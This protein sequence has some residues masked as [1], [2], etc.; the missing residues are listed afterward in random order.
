MRDRRRWLPGTLALTLTVLG[1]T[2]GQAQNLPLAPQRPEGLAA[3]PIFEGWYPN[4]DGTITLSFGYLNR[5]TE[6]ILDIPVGPSNFVSPGAEDQGQPTHFN[7]R[8]HYGLFTVTVPGDFPEDQRVRWTIDIRGQRFSIPGG[9]IQGYRIDALYAPA[10]DERPPIVVLEEGGPEA[11]GPNG[12]RAEARATVGVPLTLGARAWSETGE[13]G[14]TLRWYHYRG[15]GAV[16]FSEDTT[17]IPADSADHSAT[18]EV[19]FSQA[20]DYVVYVRANY[21]N[22]SLAGAGQEQCCW[23]NGYFD[24]T[25]AD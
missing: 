23:T 7:T 12:H 9:K 20:G 21:S 11:R 22:A 24:V 17:P 4:P 14:V 1:W 18:T 13:E 16:T 2:S 19:T 5:N 25:V 6:E 10:L 15:P 3:S 8:R